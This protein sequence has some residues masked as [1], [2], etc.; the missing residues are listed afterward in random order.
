[1]IEHEQMCSTNFQGS[2]GSMESAGLVES[3]GATVADGKL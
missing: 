1:M 2:A 3:F